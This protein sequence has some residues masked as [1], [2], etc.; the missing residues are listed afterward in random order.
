MN[1]FKNVKNYKTEPLD[2]DGAYVAAYFCDELGR[3]WYETRKGWVGAVAVDANGL[4]CSVARSS[5]QVQLFT[6]VEGQTLYEV[7]PDNIPAD[8][9]GKYNFLDGEFVIVS[10]KAMKGT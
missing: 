1:E 3:D 7:E 9:L 10:S 8:P 5:M 6:M 2:G 4:V